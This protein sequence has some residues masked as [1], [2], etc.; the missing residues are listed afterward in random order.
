[1]HVHAMCV[2]HHSDL[3]HHFAVLLLQGCGSLDIWRPRRQ[4]RGP[5]SS[6]MYIAKHT[7]PASICC[8]MSRYCFCTLVASSHMRTVCGIE[9]VGFLSYRESTLMEKKELDLGTRAVTAR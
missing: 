4:L 3:A 9:Q 7:N 5:K 1:M 8:H 6:T 2:S